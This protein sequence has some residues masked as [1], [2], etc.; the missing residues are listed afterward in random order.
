MGTHALSWCFSVEAT[1]TC[2][3]TYIYIYKSWQGKLGPLVGCA[4]SPCAPKLLPC[5][6]SRQDAALVWKHLAWGGQSWLD[7]CHKNMFQP[8]IDFKMMLF[9]TADQIPFHCRYM[10]FAKP[11]YEIAHSLESPCL[12]CRNNISVASVQAKPLEQKLPLTRLEDREGFQRQQ[13]HQ[14][15]V[16]IYI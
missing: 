10:K 13:A 5:C 11:L 6:I 14:L 12:R 8:C 2:T 4:M 3:Y 15:C 1:Y 7:L 9:F 16:Y